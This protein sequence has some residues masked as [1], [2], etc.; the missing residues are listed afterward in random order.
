MT[1][2][3]QRSFVSQLAKRLRAESVLIQVLVGPRQVGKTTG[4]QQLI[5]QYEPNSHYAN[6]DDL[7][8]GNRS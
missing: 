3:F 5:N 1:I 2:T 8:V 6:A 7:F 4:V